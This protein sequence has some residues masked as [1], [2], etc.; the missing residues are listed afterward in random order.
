MKELYLCSYTNNDNKYNICCSDQY[1]KCIDYILYNN[2]YEDD[3]E[4][5]KIS[6]FKNMSLDERRQLYQQ[7]DNAYN[8]IKLN[9]N[10]YIL[11][12][13]INFID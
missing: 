2:T 10:I 7:S 5:W 13:K 6:T 4:N 1:F 11:I 9:K 3:I 12:Q 8:I